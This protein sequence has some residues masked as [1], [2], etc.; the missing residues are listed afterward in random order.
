MLRQSGSSGRKGST[1]CK[2]YEIDN[3]QEGLTKVIAE[4]SVLE[5]IHGITHIS[6][7]NKS[8]LLLQRHYA[9][10]DSE[11]TDKRQECYRLYKKKNREK[12]DVEY[13][14]IGVC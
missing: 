4:V 13:D 9:A 2:V 14:V 10:K 6:G 12:K 3:R 11:P 1:E 5:W 8:G 7:I